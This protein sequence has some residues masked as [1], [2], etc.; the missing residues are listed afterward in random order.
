M[1]TTAGGTQS[2]GY[3]AG[4]EFPAKSDS[5][6]FCPGPDK[7]PGQIGRCPSTLEE[8]SE[9]KPDERQPNEDVDLDDRF[10]GQ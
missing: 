2:A 9:D 5:S 4:C 1:R 8:V 7:P 10:E 3:S 6:G